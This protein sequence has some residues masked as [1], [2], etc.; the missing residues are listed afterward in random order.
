MPRSSARGWRRA[1]LVPE[2]ASR[3]QRAPALV[4]AESA[5]ARAHACFGES[6]SRRAPLSHK[7][8]GAASDV[9]IKERIFGP[10]PPVSLEGLVPADQFYRR[11]EHTLD[12]GFIH[13]LVR[14]TYAGI[15]W[16]SVDPVV[17]FKL[18]LVLFFE[19]LRSER[20]LMRV[21]ADRLS[22]RWY[23][24]SPC[25]TIPASPA[26]GSATAWTPSAASSR[27]S[28]SSAARQDSSGGKSSTSTRPTSRPARRTTRSG[29]LRRR[30]P[31]G[32][33][34]CRIGAGHAIRG[35]S[36]S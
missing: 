24:A 14:E 30:G 18:Q 7:A 32:Q 12:L 5:V 36:L 11:L 31:P 17:F 29:P 3:P 27:R 15:G 22:L 16:P 23:L 2:P 8:E 10:L 13:N 35:R 33:A 20:Q 25:P 19:G 9:G 21:A 4:G 34:L 1:E 6:R 28:S 26:S